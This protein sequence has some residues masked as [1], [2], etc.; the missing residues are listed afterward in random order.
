MFMAVIRM[1]YLGLSADIVLSAR[2]S[3]QEEMVMPLRLTHQDKQFSHKTHHRRDAE[4][5]PGRAMLLG[6]YS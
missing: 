1:I 4:S 6:V 3:S 5:Q 2:P